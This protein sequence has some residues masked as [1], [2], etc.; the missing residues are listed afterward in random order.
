M[1]ADNG[2][3]VNYQDGRRLLLVEM[4]T[5]ERWVY[6]SRFFPFIKG[7]AERLGFETLWICFGTE[8][9]IEKNEPGKIKQYM[10]LTDEDAGVLKAHLKRFDPSHIIITHPVSENAMDAIRSREKEIRILSTSDLPCPDDVVRLFDFIYRLSPAGKGGGAAPGR[11]SFAP[12]ALIVK[13]D[14]L[15]NWLGVCEDECPFYGRYLVGTFKPSYDAVIGN[16]KFREFEPHILLMGGLFCDHR[17]PVSGNKY[18]EGL[19]LED[20]AHDFGCG[21]CTS[22]RGPGS[23]LS[24][25]PVS[26]AE[27]QFRRIIETAGADGRDFGVYDVHDIR[28]FRGMDRFFEMI[29]RLGV[30]PSTF[31]FE[32]RADRALET[33]DKIEKLL[34][35]LEDAGHRLLLF[36]MGAENLVEEENERFNKRISLEQIDGASVRLKELAKAHPAVFDYDPTFGYITCSPWTTL[37]MLEKGVRLAMEREFEPKGVWLY[38]P[39]LLFISAPIT[40]LAVSDGDIITA[41]FED[42]SLIYEPVV[43]SAS[44][45]SFLPWRF[46]DR[47]TGTAF[48][49]IV[50]FCAAAL[51]DKYPDTVFA[52]DELYNEM[53]RHDLGDGFFDRPDIFAVQAI[54][55]VKEDGSKSGI[56]QIMETALG[57]YAR[58]IEGGTQPE[59]PDAKDS[60]G[61]PD[62][63]GGYKLR[64]L[65]QSVKEKFDGYFKDVAI[66]ELRGIPEEHLIFLSLSVGSRNYKLYLKNSASAGKCLFTTESFAVS[67]YP[68]TPIVLEADRKKIFNLVKVLDRAVRQ[69]APDLI[70]V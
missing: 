51:R 26:V 3:Q 23:D 32:P 65:A 17:K 30:R 37:E 63:Q 19:D 27:E 5:H 1:S 33:A 54:E 18:Y 25:D 12:E 35:A 4:A 62:S 60:A 50:R 52:G 45:D 11:T 16:R 68:E 44:T 56:K 41:D 13:A 40:K 64:M 38:T 46:K 34:P 31:C 69:Y 48:A 57:R 9:A 8:L 58:L 49:L 42:P 28:L 15:L 22:Y 39:L 36:R 24:E 43:N 61:N 66:S 20:C 7:C 70:P 6:N 59:I 29:F 67:Y 2:K 53:L 21:F 55:T 47:R 14:W 10:R